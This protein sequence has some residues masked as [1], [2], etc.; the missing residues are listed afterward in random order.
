MQS[1]LNLISDTN[2]FDSKFNEESSP[3]PEFDLT[4]NRQSDQSD[5]EI[6]N[7]LIIKGSSYKST[8]SIIEIFSFLYDIIKLIKY[9]DASLLE[10]VIYQLS[11][12][13]KLYLTYCKETIIDGA[14]VI[15]GKMKSISQKH[16]I[17]LNSNSTM[18]SFLLE[19]ISENISKTFHT[20]YEIILPSFQDLLVTINNI[21]SDC[22]GKI[23]DLFYQT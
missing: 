22:K 9:L 14:G 21:N 11:K 17:L 16:I 19:K 3:L 2:I 18:L 20:K 10:T 6:I 23:Y 5:S 12:I 13:L 8:Y 7:V 1:V 15:K 4:L